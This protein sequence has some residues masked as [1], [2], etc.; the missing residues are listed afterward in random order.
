MGNA[1]KQE[2]LGK[3]ILQN[4]RNELYLDFPYLT[5]HLQ[6][7]NTRR[8]VIFPLLG[9]MERKSILIPNSLWKNMWRILL[10]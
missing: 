10:L 8:T 5:G 7:W 6:V 2:L 9:Q 3:N 1:E 4:C